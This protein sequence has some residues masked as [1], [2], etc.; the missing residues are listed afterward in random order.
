MV[1]A[2]DLGSQRSQWHYF[3]TAVMQN[4]ECIV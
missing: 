3:P 2:Y 4:D 1:L